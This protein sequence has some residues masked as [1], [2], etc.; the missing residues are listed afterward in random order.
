MQ[1]TYIMIYET[2]QQVRKQMKPKHQKLQRAVYVLWYSSLS[3]C[4]SPVY[5][6]K[7]LMDF[8]QILWN[9]FVIFGQEQIN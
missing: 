3:V 2:D 1:E 7:L 6:R 8:N 4:L 5:L 9:D